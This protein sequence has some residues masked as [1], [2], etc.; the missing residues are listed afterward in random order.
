ME[1]N[2]KSTGIDVLEN[3]FRQDKTQEL[4]ELLDEMPQVEV[5]EFLEGKEFEDVFNFL[6]RMSPIERG[7]LFGYFNE[8]SQLNYSRLMDKSSFS[9]IFEHMAS[10]TRADLY[11][12]FTEDEQNEL[13]PYLS[14]LV[15][16]DVISLSSHAP[17]TAG[18]IMT[19]DFATI[20]NDMNVEQA[21][22]K[23]RSDAPTRN[24]VYYIYVVDQRMVMTGFLTLKDIVLAKKNQKIDELVNEVFIYADVHED[25][26]SVTQKIIRYDLVAIPVLN[27]INQLVGIVRHDDAMEIIQFEQTEDIEKMMGIVPSAEDE[28]YLEISTWNH[29]K[30][31]VPWLLSLALMGL[32]SGVIIN[33]FHSILEQFIILAVYMPLMA[34]TGGNSGSQAAAVIIRAFALSEIQDQEWFKVIFKE[35]KI[36]FLLSL[37]VALLI[38]LQI[39]SFPFSRASGERLSLIN[40]ASIISL[41][42]TCQVISATS[43]GA[44]LPIIVRKFGGD[45]AI[46]ASPAITTIV[47]ITGILIYFAIANIF[48]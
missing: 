47:D 7:Q 11:Q 22:E 38:H 41:A 28:S 24:M 45:P 27:S 48:L 39:L 16:E 32:I 9:V 17:E 13:I 31:R 34:S 19:T 36:P 44:A 46:V 2:Q 12:E 23:I 10:D 25:Q 6:Q 42:I 18:A 1:E 37:S 8:D 3:L 33:R 5:A 4:V 40:I 30:R 21:I 43:L 35:I 26:E 29:Y 15:R 14:K 20:V